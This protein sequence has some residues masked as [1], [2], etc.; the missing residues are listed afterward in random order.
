[1]DR[2][3]STKLLV[4]GGC[5]VLSLV[6]MSSLCVALMAFNRPHYQEE[7]WRSVREALCGQDVVVFIDGLADFDNCYFR[8]SDKEGAQASRR[9]AQDIFPDSLVFNNSTNVGCPV[10]WGGVLSTVFDQLGYQECLILEDDLVLSP[11]YIQNTEYLLDLLHHEPR[12]GMVGCFGERHH[13][14]HDPYLDCLTTAGHLWGM[15]TWKNRWDLWRNDFY[16]FC[17]ITTRHGRKPCVKEVESLYKSWGFRGDA[18]A[19]NDGALMQIMLKNNQIPVTTVAN[20][21]KYIGVQGEF[22]T[23][24]Y[25]NEQRYSDMPYYDGH[26]N[27]PC[28][29]EDFFGHALS[30]LKESYGLQN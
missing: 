2:V 12:A 1:M 8:E 14:N 17:H 15:A 16:H 20:C 4:S 10:Q 18:S 26:I 23:P 19:V 30:K 7:V 11:R 28:P 24:D 6:V 27:M 9:I 29:G 25:Y 5:D 3:L 21:A 22:G 13:P